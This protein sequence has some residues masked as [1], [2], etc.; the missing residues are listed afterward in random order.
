MQVIPK[1]EEYLFQCKEWF[2]DNEGD[3]KTERMLK[4]AEKNV[5]NRR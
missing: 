4:V 2:A 3:G 1:V 5:Y